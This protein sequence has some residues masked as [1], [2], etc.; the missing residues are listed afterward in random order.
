MIIK[1]IIAYPDLLVISIYQEGVI[2]KILAIIN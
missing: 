2:M 1:P